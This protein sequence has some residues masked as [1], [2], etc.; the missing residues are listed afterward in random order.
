MQEYNSTWFSDIETAKQKIKVINEEIT[1]K[2][3]FK[4]AAGERPAYGL[5]ISLKDYVTATSDIK[6]LKVINEE[7]LKKQQITE[8]NT[9]YDNHDKNN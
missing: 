7:T 6:S 5:K 2:N 3:I 4:D 1:I 8:D 9:T